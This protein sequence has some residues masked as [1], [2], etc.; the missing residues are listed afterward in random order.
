[1]PGLAPAGV[2]VHI[3]SQIRSVEPFVEAL[4]RVRALVE[5]LRVDGMGIRYVDGGGGLGVEYGTAD[6]DAEAN[7]AR[8]RR[9]CGV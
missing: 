3:G 8:M 6:F 2:S 4:R 7:V 9:A 5:E 1:M